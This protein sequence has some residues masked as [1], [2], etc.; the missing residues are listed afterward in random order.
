M[1][2]STNFFLT[3]TVVVVLFG[4]VFYFLFGRGGK[5]AQ[6]EKQVNEIEQAGKK[7]RLQVESELEFQEQ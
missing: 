3:V 2:K 7:N 5:V 4:L 1:Q 6:A